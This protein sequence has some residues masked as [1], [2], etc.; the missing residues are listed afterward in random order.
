VALGTGRA[1][2]ALGIRRA[3]LLTIVAA[4]ALLPAVTALVPAIA[5]ATMGVRAPAVLRAGQATPAG[6]I[7]TVAGG[8]GGPARATG[9]GLASACGVS[10]AG[11][12][13][14]VADG[15]TVRRVSQHKDW[16]TTPAGTGVFAPLD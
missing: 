11:G 2:G 3:G 16:L 9:V 6:V 15:S 8:V 12:Y 7:T 13:L 4:A 14:Y 5:S 1:G 10:F